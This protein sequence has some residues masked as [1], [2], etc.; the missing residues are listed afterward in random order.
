MGI[1]GFYAWLVAKY[2][3]IVKK[4]N[5]ISRPVVNSLYIDFN[6]LLFHA[7]EMC[8]DPDDNTLFSNE[9]LRHLDSIV[10]FVRP[11]TLIFIAIDGTPPYNKIFNQMQDRFTNLWGSSPN[12]YDK[13][14]CPMHFHPGA[15]FISRFQGILHEFIRKKTTSDA[16]WINPQVIYSSVNNPGETEHKI[17]EFIRK[18]SELTQYREGEVHCVFS[19]DADIIPLIM[20]TSE[21]NFL[22]M[23]TSLNKKMKPEKYLLTESNFDLV[24]VNILREYLIR[25]YL[26]TDIASFNPDS[27]LEHIFSDWV[28]LISLVGNDFFKGFSYFSRKSTRDGRYLFYSPNY[29]LLMNIYETKIIR[30]DK[31]LLNTENKEIILDNFAILIK[32][33]MDEIGEDVDYDNYNNKVSSECEK[34][35]NN[36]SWTLEYYLNKCPSWAYFY[37]CDLEERKTKSFV[38]EVHLLTFSDLYIFITKNGKKYHPKSFEDGSQELTPFDYL[39]SHYPKMSGYLPISVLTR[40]DDFLQKYEQENGYADLNRIPYEDFKR[41]N[42]EASPEFTDEEIERNRSTDE[43]YIIESGEISFKTFDFITTKKPPN[44]LW[45][46]SLNRINNFFEKAADDRLQPVNYYETDLY[47]LKHLRKAIIGKVILVD[48]PFLKPFIV[49]T[50]EMKS[51]SLFSIN[52]IN[53]SNSENEILA[54]TGYPIIISSTNRSSTVVSSKLEVYPYC[55]TVPLVPK[56]ESVLNV[57]E[58]SDSIIQKNHKVLLIDPKH[59]GQIGKIKQ[60]SH[61]N[62]KALVTLIHKKQYDLSEFIRNECRIQKE[63]NF[64]AF[65]TDSIVDLER[66]LMKLRNE[67]SYDDDDDDDFNTKKNDFD[68]E[69]YGDDIV[70]HFDNLIWEGKSI[71][72]EQHVNVG[73]RA[74][75]ITHGG[76]IE[77]GEIGTVVKYDFKHEEVSVVFDRKS[78]FGCS[79]YGLLSTTRGII[80]KNYDFFL[81]K[82]VSDLDFQTDIESDSESLKDRDVILLSSEKKESPKK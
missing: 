61:K 17:F 81:I 44:S 27:K 68:K 21:N 33:F 70:V 8:I 56:L 48:Y 43:F 36:F 49:K 35:L 32:S 39:L 62:Q 23:R 40:V 77:F 59:Y 4:F 78:D 26:N 58:A 72:R 13:S 53:V 60:I 34:L 28:F 67:F 18:R 82:Q 3:L 47:P 64:D 55:L 50:V 7:K 19:N 71:K 75:S 14:Y 5:D 80:G 41:I 74:I 15:Y 24:Y 29:T 11:T 76:P 12:H 66:K 63:V 57:F 65:S 54:V 45:I 52:G 6:Q 25:D 2:P 69:I 73:D 9:V 38:D 37:S 51:I 30:Q 22:L 42:R 20:L 10:Q 46:P 79:L 16:A 1:P 31:S